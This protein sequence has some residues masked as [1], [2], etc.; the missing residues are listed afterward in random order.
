M[1]F[2]RD[3]MFSQDKQDWNTPL[4]TFNRLNEVFHFTKDACTSPDNPLGTETFFTPETHGLDCKKWVGPT[5]VN[6]PYKRGVI[7]QWVMEGVRYQ[8][9]FHQTSVFLIPARTG[10]KLWQQI[11]YKHAKLICYMEKRQH[12]SNHDNAAPF[13]S[14]LILFSHS[15]SN[16][17]FNCFASF[18]HVERLK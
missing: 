4:E 9:V 6:P 7:T 11:I 2:N 17:Q 15:P 12:F 14:A 3:L 18:G 8:N 5:F 10:N 1:S 13:D 16:K